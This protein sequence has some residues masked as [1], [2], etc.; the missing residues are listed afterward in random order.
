MK[1]Q[2]TLAL[3]VFGASLANATMEYTVPTL[4]LA[5]PLSDFSLTEGDLLGTA[6]PLPDLLQPDT[7]EAPNATIV[8]FAF[9]DDP[10]APYAWIEL[11][12]QR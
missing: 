3:F 4:N 9:G 8:R 10:D 7:I 6:G 12:H 11:F 2:T 1:L 5:V